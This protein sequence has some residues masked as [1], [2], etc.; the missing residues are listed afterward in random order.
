MRYHDL[1]E[2][3]IY[4]LQLCQNE[5]GRR[6]AEFIEVGKDLN[7]NCIFVTEPLSYEFLQTQDG[8]QLE[9]HVSLKDGRR[10]GFGGHGEW[11]THNEMESMKNYDLGLSKVVQWETVNAPSFAPK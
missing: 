5:A 9:K 3:K 2:G 4:V 8:K 11:F 1:I 7:G 6:Y 10:F